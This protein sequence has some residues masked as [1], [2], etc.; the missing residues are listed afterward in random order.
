MLLFDFYGL[1][2]AVNTQKTAK[3][4]CYQLAVVLIEELGEKVFSTFISLFSSFHSTQNQQT[5]ADIGRDNEIPLFEMSK[6]VVV[7]I[8]QQGGETL[9]RGVYIVIPFSS[10][11]GLLYSLPYSSLNSE[12]NL[13]ARYSQ[14]ASTEPFT[15]VLRFLSGPWLKIVDTIPPCD[16]VLF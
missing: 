13:S 11:A 16:K 10:G 2:G 1:E 5:A 6:V 14:G 15:G 7:V 9:E 8:P 12:E 4:L 3:W